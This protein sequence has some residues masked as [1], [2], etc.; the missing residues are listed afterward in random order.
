MSRAGRIGGVALRQVLL[1]LGIT[2]AVFVL[3]RVVPGDAVDVMASEGDIT[4]AQEDLL[5]RMLGLD[6]GWPG[7]LLAWGSDALMGDL[8][9]SLR[10][11]QPV[12]DM[13]WAALPVTLGLA[14]AGLAI[15]LALGVAL[16]LLAMLRPGLAALVDALNVWS[17]VMP[18]FCVGLAGILVFSVWLGWLP[19][20]GHGLVPA[21]IIGLDIGGQIAK[22]LM[23]DLRETAEARFVTALRSRGVRRGAL[24]WRHL[25]PNSLTAVL[26][27]AGLI[28]AGLVGGTLTM[29]VLFGLPGLGALLLDAILGR[30]YPVVQAAIL[31]LSAA[32]IAANLATEAMQRALDP[33]VR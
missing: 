30:D 28:V 7:Q 19:S 9:T 8:G 1:L 4:V 6:I 16:A 15:G 13:V 5:R 29:E 3:L 12:S 22:P 27:L 11:G 20:L 21:A 31:V 24:V 17:I 26:P 33:R 25:L 32:V 23:E 10:Y 14:A 18:T 2:V